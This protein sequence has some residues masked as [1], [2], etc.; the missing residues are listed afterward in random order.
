MKERVYE[1]KFAGGVNMEI[2]Y[3]ILTWSQH[4]R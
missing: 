2:V 3:R 4:G 1:K